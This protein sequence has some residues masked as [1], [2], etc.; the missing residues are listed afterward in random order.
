MLPLLLAAVMPGLYWEQPAESADHLHQAGIERLYVPGGREAAWRKAGF[1]AMA[2]DK[3]AAQEAVSPDVE[4]H[5]DVASATRVP[6]INANGWRFER[7]PAAKYF[8]YAKPGSAVL[9]AA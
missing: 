6:W 5:M 9:A 4:Y 2:F 7:H 1:D 3:T 8:S